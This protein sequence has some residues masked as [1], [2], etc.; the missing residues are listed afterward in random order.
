V[1]LIRLVS[2]L[3]D[4]CKAIACLHANGFLHLELYP[5]NVLVA[6]AS[7]E[8]FVTC[9]HPSLPP[10]SIEWTELTAV[11]ALGVPA[12]V[13]PEQVDPDRL[14]A[15]DV[16]TDVYGLGGILFDILYDLPPNGTPHASVPQFLTALAARKG[17]PR[18][19]T[20]GTRA[21]RCHKL[22]RKLEP[23]S[24]RALESDRTARQVSASAF[25]SEVEQCAWGCSG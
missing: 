11:R 19:G 12:Y 7:Q 21:A 18:P 25:M 15:P 4:V 2:Y 23:I 22:A 9:G 10:M 3:L 16:L 20:L 8:V 1:T 14:G 6:P 17:P 24:L 13:A 5:G